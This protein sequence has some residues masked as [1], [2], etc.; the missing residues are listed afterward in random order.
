MST[1]CNA[2]LNGTIL[3][4]F[5]VYV[6]A[7]SCCAIN[8][9]SK[10]QTIKNQ[11]DEGRL[12]SLC[13]ESS[14]ICVPKKNK[15]QGGIFMAAAFGWT[16]QGSIL[17]TSNLLDWDGKENNGVPEADMIQ[18]HNIICSSIARTF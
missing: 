5:G 11:G 7:K 8:K 12:V 17:P 10:L 16:M 14:F 2:V 6:R 9:S 4:S 18:S 15:N 13:N 1:D 3:G